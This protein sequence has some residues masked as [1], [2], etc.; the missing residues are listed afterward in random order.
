L[1][2]KLAFIGEANARSLTVDTPVPYRLSDLIR[3]IEDAMGLLG[4]PEAVAAYR[5]LISRIA[6]VREDRRY[7]FMFQ[8]MVVRDSMEAVLGKVLRLPVAGKPVTVI[9]ISGVPSE[10][11]NIVVSVL[12]RILFEFGLWSERQQG[13]PLLLVCEEAHRYVPG[14]VSLGFGPTRRAIDQIAKEGRKYG[15]SLCL[16]SQRP[17]EL[18]VNSISQC[19]TIFALRMSNER[20][21]NFVRN[22]LPDGSEWL[23]RTLPA[24]GTGEAIAVGEGVAIPSQIPFAPLPANEQPASHTPSFS[25]SWSREVDGPATLQST[26]A[27]W[28]GLQR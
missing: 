18:S 23:I 17:S 16:V 26:I 24:L 3:I 19:G 21:Q 27:R 7:A 22:A 12:C 10:I 13:V 6:G 25:A 11:V 8:S 9:D 28:R 15:V 2:A 4:K 1:R 5:H 14:D 20:D